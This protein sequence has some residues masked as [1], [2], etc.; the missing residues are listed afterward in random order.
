MYQYG[1]GV[2]LN[3]KTAIKWYKK[4]VTQGSKESFNQLIPLSKQGP[5]AGQNMLGEM[6]LNGIV[7]DQNTNKAV[8]WFLRSA[9]QEN[10]DAI[11]SLTKLNHQREL[12]DQ[13][14]LG[15]AYLR[16]NSFKNS[17]SLAAECFLKSAKKGNKDAQYHLALGYQKGSGIEQSDS[18]AFK[19]FSKSN[20]QGNVD[21]ENAIG[22]FYEQGRGVTQ[23]KQKALTLY[24]SAAKKGNKKAQFNLSAF[25]YELSDS[26]SLQRSYQWAV[27]AK[28][29][30]FD[31]NGA[32]EIIKSEMSNADVNEANKHIKRC[33]ASHYSDCL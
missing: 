9:R 18:E 14:N 32:I 27:I 12:S 26:K 21:A 6:Y 24:L 16:N 33:L 10:I 2:T 8:I 20:A 31:T 19:W 11:T 5:S 7:I 28:K 30:G 17:N 13:Y 1:K 22:E 15:L 23:D 29:N 4:A 25:Y 3:K